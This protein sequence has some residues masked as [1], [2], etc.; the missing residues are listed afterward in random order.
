MEWRKFGKAFLFPPV[1]VLIALFPISAV[2]LAWSM[3]SPDCAGHVRV[4]FCVLAFYTLVIWCARVPEMIRF[5]RKFRRENR[6]VRA[7][8]DDVRLRTNVTLGG[9]ALWNGAYALLQLGMGIYHGSVWFYFLAAYYATL[10][11][12]R[13]FLVRHSLHHRPGEI[14]R[15]ELV[16]YRACGWIFLLT[17]LAFSGMMLYMIWDNRAVR[18]SEITTIALAAYAFVTLT[19]AIVG[20]VRYRKFNSPVVSAAKTVSLAAACVSMLTLENT[21]L[22][23]FGDGN[24]TSATTRMFLAVS[25]GAV[26]FFIV[27]MAIH[28]IAQ[29]NRKIRYPEGTGNGKQG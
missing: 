11:S 26:S 8:T 2:G 9:S 4:F 14:I 22:A 16:R 24:M 25:G 6:F 19:A 18:H 10:A 13:F 1:A 29:A 12:M 21:M 27:A 23:T 28:M 5:F 3:T 20:V 17:N 7:W 15:R